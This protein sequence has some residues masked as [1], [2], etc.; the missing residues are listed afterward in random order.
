MVERTN[1]PLSDTA[2]QKQTLLDQKAQVARAQFNNARG[3]VSH[4]QPTLEGV[5]RVLESGQQQLRTDAAAQTLSRQEPD[6]PFNQTEEEQ[7]NAWWQ[8]Q[9]SM[10]E[11][12]LRNDTPTAIQ[13]EALQNVLNMVIRL[14]EAEADTAVAEFQKNLLTEFGAHFLSELAA[15]HI[16][17]GER[18]KR[19]V[20]IFKKIR[21]VFTSF[22]YAIERTKF[23]LNQL[24]QQQNRLVDNARHML[25]L[26]DANLS[27]TQP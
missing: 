19:S 10:A 11:A 21:S 25:T 3:Q 12:A 16:E 22:R 6:A 24:N 18:Q 26:I 13:R 4:Q 15:P 9:F 1:Q 20:I 7:T 23:D 14:T 17:T 8:A 2:L 27:A 5:G